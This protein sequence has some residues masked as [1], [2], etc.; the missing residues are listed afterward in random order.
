M[1]PIVGI[2]G[3]GVEPRASECRQCM[4]S[5]VGVLDSG[6]A[7]SGV[8]WNWCE[9][10]TDVDCVEEYQACVLCMCDNIYAM[11]NGVIVIV[12]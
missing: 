3:V 10:M 2:C 5:E 1:D 4:Y 8:V 6:N 11:A 7:E 9:K 12:G